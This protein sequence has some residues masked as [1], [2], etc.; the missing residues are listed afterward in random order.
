FIFMYFL[1][2]GI[3]TYEYR[4]LGVGYGVA[5]TY[6]TDCDICL[7]CAG[8]CQY[9]GSGVADTLGSAQCT[10]ATGCSAGNN[11]VCNGAA[12]CYTATGGTCSA[13]NQ[14]LST[15][16]V[17]AYCRASCSGYTTTANRCSV[18][19][20][21]YTAYGLCTLAAA[22]DTTD[23]AYNSAYYSSCAHA[24]AAYGS[25]CDSGSL[26]GG[27]SANGVCGGA[28][29]S[30]C[31]L[32]YASDSTS[33]ITAS[34]VFGTAAAVCTGTN[35]YY[36]DSVADGS[37]SPGTQ[38][39][40]GSD[41]ACRTCSTHVDSESLCESG[42]G[43][44]AACDELAVGTYIT[45]CNGVGQTYLRDICGSAS[46]CTIADQ[47]I[48][49]S[50]GTGCT[51]S[52]SCEG[53]APS[54]DVASCS[55][56][57]TYIADNCGA[58]CA[59]ADR[60][61]SVCRGT[62]FAASCTAN[63]SSDGKTLNACDGTSGFI[64]STCYYF[65]DGDSNNQTC[66]CIE[67]VWKFNIGGE[68]SGCCGD[69][70]NEYNL[71]QVF[72][73]TMDGAVDGSV[74]CCNS[75]LDCIDT[76]GC[77][78]NGS[79]F[80]A[81]ANGDLD[82]CSEGTWKDCNSNSHC[83]GTQVCAMTLKNC[84]DSDGYIAIRNLGTTGIENV[85]DEYTSTRNVFLE[86]NYTNYA[87][88]C[89]YIN[90]DTTAQIPG[91]TEDWT[92]WET[93]VKRMIWILSPGVG[94][95]T[96]YFQVN[97]SAPDIRTATFNDS[98]FYNF[99]GAGL[100]TTP[101]SAPTIVDGDYVSDDDAIPV[102]WFGVTDPES[103]ILNI[104]M[105]YFLMLIHSNGTVLM[106]YTTYELSHTFNAS[107]FG[108]P[109]STTLYV[110][111][112]AINSAELTSTNMSDGVILDFVAPTA[113]VQAS[114]KNATSSV[115]RQVQSGVWLYTY[116]INMSWTGNDALSGAPAAYS[117]TL[118]QSEASPDNVPEGTPGS[119]ESHLDKTYTNLQPGNYTFK[120]KARDRAGNWGSEASVNFLV[121]VTPSS[122]PRIISATSAANEITFEWTECSDQESDVLR[123]RVLL[124]NS[125]GG[126]V[127]GVNITGKTNTEHTFTGLGTSE[128][129]ATVGAENGAGIWR[130]SYDEQETFDFTPPTVLA[131]PN[132]TV[133]TSSPVLKAWTDEQSVCYYTQV[134]TDHMFRYTNT[135]YHEVKVNGLADGNYTYNIICHDMSGNEGTVSI[136]FKVSVPTEPNY[137][138]ATDIT[139]YESVITNF[140]VKTIA[141]LGTNYENLTGI[142]AW[143]MYIDDELADISVFDVGDGDFNVSFVAPETA[144]TYSLRLIL[145]E[146]DINRTLV[147]Q[148][149]YLQTEY[150]EPGMS[151]ADKEYITYVTYGGTRIVGIA[152]NS[153]ES[154][155]A[156]SANRLKI[157]NIESTKD[158][159]L[160]NTKSGA[161]LQ[162]RDS[163]LKEDKLLSKIN[164]SFGYA[165]TDNYIV[166]FILDYEDID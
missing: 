65:N 24:S 39:C 120:V 74:G 56:G 93:C 63:S 52:A 33:A 44:P 27:Y 134:D 73:S 104:P 149:L 78:S 129:N 140:N 67:G 40:D 100:D 127:T 48:C 72:D 160:F 66:N 150:A 138:Q 79:V 81:D 71:T 23:A 46:T 26:S 8:T 29:H 13:G 17:E 144:G 16:C 20:S 58:A 159:Y 32:A 122:R 50:A 97:Y 95:K 43:A 102:S 119:F 145:D 19:G 111:V 92:A 99:S 121:D 123:Y 70:A 83:T 30:T 37:F 59:A 25:S 112:S 162:S 11:C 164:P 9:V 87:V 84:V 88:S 103:D 35:A 142:N 163:L 62:A 124:Y 5:C 3:S 146:Y 107:S 96:V 141:D 77:Y 64:N 34:S 7:N 105:R 10:G 61:E 109:H 113:S 53:V 1:T 91:D 75:A 132:K 117:Y 147:V 151:P 108:L 85:S 60:A 154:Q 15:Y 55:A 76:S 89:R 101:P 54:T 68:I 86:L 136:T 42:C 36:C 90:F 82:F 137:L 118:S 28:S 157:S 47:N 165:I 139:T 152:T 14:C 161:S 148:D 106:N 125:S 41:T 98:I 69:D 51:A 4:A 130:W 156:S 6:E 38:R 155:I 116:Q 2:T 131:L 45:T 49:G 31:Y 115:I 12:V 135:T 128:Y 166:N 57:L 114:Y 21:A 126:Y 94:N 158:I 22:C 153:R 18:T 80:Y 110:N 133:I 143:Q